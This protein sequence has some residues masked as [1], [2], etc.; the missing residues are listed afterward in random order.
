MWRANRID[1]SIWLITM[2]TSALVNTELGLLVG[3]LVSAFCVLGRTQ[4]TQ[5]LKLGQ[6]GHRDLFKALSTYKG[7]ETQHNI[8]VFQYEA[9]I[10]YANQA[11]FKKNLYSSVGIHSQNDEARRKQKHMEKKMSEPDETTVFVP[12][13]H[14]LV[15]DCSAVVFLDTAGVGAL[16]EVYKEYKKLGVRLLLVQC[17]TSVIDSL[18]RGGYYDPKTGSMEPIFHTIGDAVCYA[19]NLLSQNGNCETSC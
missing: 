2:A 5:A 9:P 11:L 18:R 10:Y 17:N 3:V 12:S 15:L 14:T 7:L 4:R 1:A 6:V 16:K 13:V 8:A 19:E